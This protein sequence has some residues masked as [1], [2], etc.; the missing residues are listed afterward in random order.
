MEPSVKGKISELQ[1]ISELLKKGFEVYVPVVDMCVDCIIKSK[2]N[3]TA[4]T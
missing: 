1:V 2:K 4:K 3:K